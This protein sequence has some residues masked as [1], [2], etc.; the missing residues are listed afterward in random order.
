MY[1]DGKERYR[2]IEVNG[3]KADDSTKTHEGIHSRNEFGSMLRG[4]FDPDVAAVYKWSGR[5]MAMGVLC[6][7]F[8][9]E[10]AKAKSNFVLHWGGKREPVG[11]TGRVFIEEETGMVRR[12]TIQG[13]GLPKDFGLQSPAFS[14]D[15]GIVK[16]GRK[17]ICCR[18]ARRCNCGMQSRLCE[19]KRVFR[20]YRKFDAESEIKFQ[21]I[22]KS[23]CFA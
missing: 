17:T 12:L 14:L 7:V 11:Y 4:L 13:I 5:S 22:K 15:Y 2:T 3:I 23:K 6:Q 21:T 16:I 1:E 9:V 18:S 19:T 10:V 20:G 8:D